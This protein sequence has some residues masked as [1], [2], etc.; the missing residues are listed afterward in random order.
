MGSV[1]IILQTASAWRSTFPCIRPKNKTGRNEI[2]ASAPGAK[3]AYV[4]SGVDGRVLLTLSGRATDK[5]FGQHTSGVG[6]I[7]GD[8][9]AD[10]IV[11]APGD[12]SSAGRA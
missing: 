10:V 12:K 7:D 5:A 11:G 9:H 1:L 3:R 4:Y 8:G 2:L 6:D